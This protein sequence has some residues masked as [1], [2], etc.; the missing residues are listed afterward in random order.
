[1]RDLTARHMELTASPRAR[2]I[3]DHWQE[4]QSRFIKAFPHEFKR[5]LGVGRAQHAYIPSQRGPALVYDG[6]LSPERVQSEPQQRVQ[7]G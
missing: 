4:I 5:V 2:W 3:L 1:V 7:H 6:Q